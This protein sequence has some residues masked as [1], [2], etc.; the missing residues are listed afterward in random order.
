METLTCPRCRTALELAGRTFRCATCEGV[1]VT[2]EALVAILEQRA[3]TLVDLPWR[4][5]EDAPRPCAA[6]GT[7]MQTVD[8]GDV[9]LDRC[10]DH[11]VWCD[12][13]EL[14]ALLREA[15]QFT[16]DPKTDPA[17]GVFHW[18]GRLLGR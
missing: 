13:D 3:S 6:C 17:E 5:R 16:R 1:W 14:T 2:E 11:G 9:A 10:A 4:A 8:L 18:L 15:K 12:C 7:A